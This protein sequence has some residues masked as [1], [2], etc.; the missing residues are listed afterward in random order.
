MR[1]TP[2][3]AARRSTP[4]KLVVVELV[5]CVLNFRVLKPPQGWSSLRSGS[6]WM[7]I[8]LQATTRV[9]GVLLQ[10]RNSNCGCNQVWASLMWARCAPL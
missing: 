9:A 8:D 4:H 2:D 6:G 1:Q 10:G 7:S 5:V 3:T